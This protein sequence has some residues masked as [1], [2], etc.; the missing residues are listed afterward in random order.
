[1]Y[2]FHLGWRV[3]LSVDQRR[4]LKCMRHVSVGVVHV[5]NLIVVKSKTGPGRASVV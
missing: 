1:M 2:L 4:V 3:V 5:E